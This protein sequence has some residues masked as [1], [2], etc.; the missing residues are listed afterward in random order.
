MRKIL[1]ILACLLAPL[2]ALAQAQVQQSPTRLDAMTTVS[3]VAASATG[4][5]LT[6][7]QPYVYIGWINISNCEDAT[8]ILAA[9]ATTSITSTNL[10]GLTY[11][12]GSGL[13]AASGAG[14]CAQQFTDSFSAPLK[15]SAPGPVTI[16]TPTFA[17]HM[18]VRVTVGWY[19][20]P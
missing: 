17:T 12:I 2:P 20:A 15:A 13:I 8:G 10:Q 3:T 7:Q 4:L 18:T 1:C 19:S 6:P 16:T 14:V 5:V 9:A 11:Q